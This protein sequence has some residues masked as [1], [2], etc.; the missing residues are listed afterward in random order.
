MLSEMEAYALLRNFLDLPASKH[1]ES[2][3][4]SSRSSSQAVY[5]W[6]IAIQW[7]LEESSTNE[8]I[9]GAVEESTNMQQMSTEDGANHFTLFQEELARCGCHVPKKASMTRYFESTDPH[10]RSGLH[11]FCED[12]RLVTMAQINR[13]AKNEGEVLLQYGGRRPVTGQ[14]RGVPRPSF[15]HTNLAEAGASALDMNLA[16]GGE[17]DIQGIPSFCSDLTS[18]LPPNTPTVVSKER[19]ATEE[20]LALRGRFKGRPSAS[21]HVPPMAYGN[22]GNLNLL[23]LL[24]RRLPLGERICARLPDSV[25]YRDFLI[26]KLS[27]MRRKQTSLTFRACPR[28]AL[29]SCSFRSCYF[30][31]ISP[32][33]FQVRP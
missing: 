14:Q 12:I 19:T 30:S 17:K 31:N 1:F 28:P 23:A 16:Q 9:Q 4:R 2:A 5:D 11:E 8:A 20:V 21:H 33:F 26:S 3:T 10:I 24:F 7:L 15:R 18:D 29:S 13:K 22:L 32:S 27:P 25:S 6:P